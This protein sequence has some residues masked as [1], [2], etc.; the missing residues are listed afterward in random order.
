MIRD[1]SI[2]GTYRTPVFRDPR[3]ETHPTMNAK[4]PIKHTLD[5]SDMI[6]NSYV[7]DLS[8]ADLFLIPVPG[9]NHIAWQLGH[10][11]AVE[12][13]AV[14]GIKPDSCPELPAGFEGIHSTKPETKGTEPGQFYSKADYLKFYAAQRAAT[15]AVID[16]LSDADLDQPSTGSFAQIAPTVGAVLN[17]V[18]QHYLMHAGQFVPVRRATGK[19]VTI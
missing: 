5:L 12:R 8:D 4:D 18:G 19:P 1:D 7:G 15:K 6:V 13:M 11:I 9:M 17:L 10:L 16:S 14:E 3:N 2:P